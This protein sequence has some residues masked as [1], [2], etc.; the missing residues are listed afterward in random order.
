MYNQSSQFSH[1]VHRRSSSTR[2][3]KIYTACIII[4]I[5]KIKK[6]HDFILEV[7]SS[8]ECKRK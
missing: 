8:E 3:L 6:K 2:L 4:R 7:Y 1:V 5:I